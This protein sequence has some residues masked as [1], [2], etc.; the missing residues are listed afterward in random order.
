MAKKKE[1]VEETPASNAMAAVGA[2]I[3]AAIREGIESARPKKITFANRVPKT[4]WSP[5]DGSRKTPLKRKIYQHGLLIQAGTVTN[6]EI[7]L[8]NQLKPGSYCSGFITVVRRKDR[9]LNIDYKIKTNSDKLKLSSQYGIR[10]F[11][12]LIQRL[13][14]EGNNP[15]SYVA[16][17]DLD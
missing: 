5:K 2:E 13:V 14:A 16:P 11:T 12:E 15:A 10:N 3:A 7:D 8:L 9:G 1:T 4:P 17:E 6:E